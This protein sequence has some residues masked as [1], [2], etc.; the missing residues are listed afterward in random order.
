M[1]AIIRD[2]VA[3]LAF[4]D[5]FNTTFPHECRR[6]G[7]NEGII[8]KWRLDD[9]VVEGISWLS[10]LLSADIMTDCFFI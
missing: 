2:D 7:L 3:T 9:D 1:V 8:R 10:I 6:S 5:G 4:C